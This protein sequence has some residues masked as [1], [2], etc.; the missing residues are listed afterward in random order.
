M[1]A[2]RKFSHNVRSNLSCYGIALALYRPASVLH[3]VVRI[4]INTAVTA[5]GSR[6]VDYS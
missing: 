3:L 1:K 5:F 4:N 2:P 6:L